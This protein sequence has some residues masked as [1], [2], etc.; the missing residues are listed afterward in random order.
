MK[1]NI[2]FPIA[3]LLFVTVLVAGYFIGLERGFDDGRSEWTSLP[4]YTKTYDVGTIVLARL[5]GLI[6]ADPLNPNTAGVTSSTFA[7]L[8]DNI[9][10]NVLPHVWS[11][12]P[13]SLIEIYPPKLSLIVRGNAALH[14]DL[15]RF[16]AIEQLNAKEQIVDYKDS[17]SSR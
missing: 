15:E 13:N 8:V 4:T 6:N 10:K 12:D 1:R 16:L 14:H 2:Q 11:S 17:K 3:F 9:H 7:P 5:D